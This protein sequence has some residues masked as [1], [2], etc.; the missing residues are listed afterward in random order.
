M[1]PPTGPQ[2]PLSSSG[3]PLS[4]APPRKQIKHSGNGGG[5]WKT[6]PTDLKGGVGWSDEDYQSL[7]HS[8]EFRGT[9]LGQERRAESLLGTL[10]ALLSFVSLTLLSDNALFSFLTFL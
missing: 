2:P 4:Q 6:R 7:W 10:P 3:N 1:A 8:L 5:G 9:N